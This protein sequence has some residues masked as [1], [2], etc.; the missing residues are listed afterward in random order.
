MDRNCSLL[1]WGRARKWGARGEMDGS[2]ILP[3]LLLWE[4]PSLLIPSS[5]PGALTPSRTWLKRRSVHAGGI[6]AIPMECWRRYQR[7]REALGALRERKRF[8][9]F[10]AQLCSTEWSPRLSRC[11]HTCPS[12]SLARRDTVSWRFC[13]GGLRMGISA[14]QWRGPAGI[15]VLGLCYGPRGLQCSETH[16]SKGQGGTHLF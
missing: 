5:I 6:Q 15:P 13:T 11:S 10:Q 7:N 12:S 8:S 9:A 1:S 4:H 16:H 3:H 2:I 14:W